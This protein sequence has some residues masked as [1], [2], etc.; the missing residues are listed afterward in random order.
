MGMEIARS[1]AS[2]VDSQKYVIDILYEIGMLVTRP[3]ISPIDQNYK[4]GEAVGKPIDE[5]R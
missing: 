1:I 2:I 5:E 3:A 4:I